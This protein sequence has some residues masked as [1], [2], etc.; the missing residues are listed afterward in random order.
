[1]IRILFPHPEPLLPDRART[2]AIVETAAALARRGAA[3]T[4]LL[5]DS[6]DHVRRFAA[7]RLGLRLPDVEIVE[8]AA[9]HRAR[10]SLITWNALVHRAVARALATRPSD[11]ATVLL[12]RGEKLAE[13]LVRR[14]VTTRF[15]MVFEAH[16]H[17]P[18]YER[19]HGRPA[20]RVRRAE[21]RLA[22]ILGGASGL[23]A[24]SEG[25]R[26]TLVEGHGFRGPAAVARSGV[27]VDLFAPAWHRHGS[28]RPPGPPRVVYTGRFGAW[29]GI[30]TLLVAMVGV[31][32]ATLHLAGGAS[33]EELRAVERLVARLGLSERVVFRG[34]VPHREVPGLLASADA[35]VHVL[36]PGR[37]VSERDTSPLKILEA[38]AVG[39]PL[40]APDLSPVREILGR[41]EA[42]LLVPPG[43]PHGLTRALL[44]L[45][46]DQSL[47]CRLS[48]AGRGIAESC[49]WD[50]RATRLLD[51]ADRVLGRSAG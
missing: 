13:S 35:A 34:R 25:L 22:T 8:L 27:D 4:L 28:V 10:G 40:V 11:G 47:A 23:A 48:A 3:L 20:R 30:E 39:T 42:A 18:D 46:S 26:R 51:L 37:S 44:R 38:L 2:I 45:L 24:I 7:D 49:S 17:A 19:E 14:G 16:I 36:A 29:K 6:A 50:A 9:W 15:P 1:M 31:A 5:P 12:V 21:R 33:G 43:D 32:G 41:T